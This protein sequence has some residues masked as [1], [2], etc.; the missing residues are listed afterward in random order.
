MKAPFA[1]FFGKVFGKRTANN[2]AMNAPAPQAKK[3]A[4]RHFIPE[5][6][7][8]FAPVMESAISALHRRKRNARNRMQKN[9]RKINFAAG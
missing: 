1:N 4:E 9:S 6:V 7:Y 2:P 5:K 8:H 3:P